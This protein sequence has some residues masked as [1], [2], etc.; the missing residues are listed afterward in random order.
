MCPRP[1]VPEV[2]ER[3]RPGKPSVLYSEIRVEN[4]A[5]RPAQLPGENPHDIAAN[6]R[7][8]GRAAAYIENHTVPKLDANGALV[9]NRGIL[10]KAEDMLALRRK[11][12]H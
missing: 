10:L 4:P 6:R 11:S 12:G 8:P 9:C 3:R 5:R 7:V 1:E 2:A